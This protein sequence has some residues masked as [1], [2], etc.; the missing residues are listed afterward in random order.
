[1]RQFGDQYSVPVRGYLYYSLDGQKDA[2]ARA[3]WADMQKIAG[4][5]QIVAFGSRYKQFGTIRRGAGPTV[6]REVDQKELARL[7]QQLDDQDQAKRDLASEELKRLGSAAEPKLRE[8]EGKASAE[9]KARIAKVLEELRPDP[10]PVA[11][12][13]IKARADQNSEHVQL[14]RKFPSAFSPS[15]GSVAA[16]GAVKLVAGISRR[17]I[18]RRNIRLRLRMPPARR[19]AVGPSGRVKSRRN[20]RRRC[21]SRAAR[22]IPGG[23][24]SRM[25]KAAGRWRM[26]SFVATNRI[27]P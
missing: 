8:A 6:G 1:M 5:G 7:I 14:L 16:A 4:T 19:T 21:R 10:Y 18:R 23:C 22:N 11:F 9:A 24:S 2:A 15:D 12:G 20:G 27:R 25:P 13:L 17:P 3:E 26:R